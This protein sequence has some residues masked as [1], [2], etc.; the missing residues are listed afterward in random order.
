[1]RMRSLKNGLMVAFLAAAL[2]ALADIQT[3]VDNNL[4]APVVM[5]N[6]LEDC[7]A[8]CSPEEKSS[9]IEQ[10]VKAGLALESIAEVALTQGM[11]I[12]DVIAGMT[13]AGIDAQILAVAISNGAATAAAN[14]VTFVD[15]EGNLIAAEDISTYVLAAIT[16]AQST[17]AGPAGTAGL[18]PI[19]VIPTIPV[20][21]V[22]PN[23]SSPAA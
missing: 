2:P 14:G 5:E 13:A 8:D 15:S 4:S 18:S 9:I 7:G 20:P 3:D 10:M 16:D 17:A 11:S 21:P 12:A 22:N 6:A 19:V 1:M 23:E